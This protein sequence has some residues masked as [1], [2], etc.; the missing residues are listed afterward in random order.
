MLLNNSVADRK[1]QSRAAPTRALGR[2]E[3]VV[4]PLDVIPADA[5]AGIGNFHRYT[6]GSCERLD[7]EP[8]AGWHRVLGVQDQIQEYLLELVLVAQNAWQILAQ[9]EPHLDPGAGQL[10]L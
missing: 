1:A 2:E 4:N 3:R 6:G 7:G 9:L 8:S 5:L 10:V